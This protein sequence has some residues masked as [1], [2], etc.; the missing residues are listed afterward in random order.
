MVVRSLLESEDTIGGPP[1]Q[2]KRD[3]G[4]VT[5]KRIALKRII[6]VVFSLAAP[7]LAM[8]QSTHTG[9]PPSA[10]ASSSPAPAS[11]SSS[12][13]NLKLPASQNVPD[14]G[15]S[16]GKYY[17]DTGGNGSGSSST[18]VHGSVTTMMGY[19][20]GYGTSTTAGVNLNIDHRTDSGNHVRLE[21]NMMQG[22]GFPGYGYGYGGYGYRR[23][24]PPEP[25][26]PPPSPSS[27][28]G[29]D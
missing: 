3:P 13:L 24:G 25:P 20:K 10:S 6:S 28:S 22:N 8:G 16:P 4:H 18:T 14:A 26:P 5:M 17:G 2:R 27:S 7:S 11:A 19:S 1:H 12:S 23:W 21:I 15:D 29:G 9:T